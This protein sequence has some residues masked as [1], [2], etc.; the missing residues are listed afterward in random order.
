MMVS[1]KTTQSKKLARCK[2]KTTKATASL[3]TATDNHTN[4]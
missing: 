3:D 1:G 2:Y 4:Y